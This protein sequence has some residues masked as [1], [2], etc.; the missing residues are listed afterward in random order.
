MYMNILTS[1]QWEVT[2]IG[3]GQASVSL[4]KEGIGNG[5]EVV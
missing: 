4:S 5:E 3:V 2:S 1:P